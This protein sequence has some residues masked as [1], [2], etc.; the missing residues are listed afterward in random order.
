MPAFRTIRGRVA[1]TFAH[2]KILSGDNAEALEIVH[3]Y[4]ATMPSTSLTRLLSKEAQYG[5]A[6]WW[7][8][9]RIV[10]LRESL[11][12]LNVSWVHGRVQ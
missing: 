10:R 6:G 7:A 5:K 11:K 9:C 1:A 12:Y 4:G 2:N 8:A 3:K